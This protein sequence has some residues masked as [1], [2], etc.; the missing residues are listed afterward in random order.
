MMTI[1][2][3]FFLNLIVWATVFSHISYIFNLLLKCAT[4]FTFGFQTVF[5]N[6]YFFIWGFENFKNTC[7]DFCCWKFGRMQIFWLFIGLREFIPFSRL[8][9][10]KMLIIVISAICCSL[11][12]Q[13]VTLMQLVFITH[14]I[15]IFKI[16]N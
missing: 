14:P 13:C 10:P 9:F 11:R 4:N 1:K 8:N 6:V 7:D 5:M 3:V 16:K 2:I 12:F 15:K